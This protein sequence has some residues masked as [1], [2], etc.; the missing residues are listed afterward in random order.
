MNGDRK[1]DKIAS[2]SV[3]NCGGS[4]TLYT[5]KK[6]NLIGKVGGMIEMHNIYPTFVQFGSEFHYFFHKIELQ[7]HKTKTFSP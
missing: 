3:I 2:F 6:N 5:G 7:K 4:A 1:K